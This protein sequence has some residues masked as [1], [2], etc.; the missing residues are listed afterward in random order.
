[1][2]LLRDPA[3]SL[4][5]AWA[6]NS[7][8]HSIIY[9]FIPIYLHEGRNL[10]MALVGTIFPLMGLAVILAPPLA[11]F[12]ADRLESARSLAVRADAPG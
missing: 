8:A 4:A 10:P 2:K 3:N 11:G 9:P 7:M 5:S 12:A 1:M 6:I